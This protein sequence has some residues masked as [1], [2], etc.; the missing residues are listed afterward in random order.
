MRKPESQSP[1]NGDETGSTVAPIAPPKTTAAE[2]VAP[3]PIP[4]T[5]TDTASTVHEL[6]SNEVESATAAIENAPVQTTHLLDVSTVSDSTPTPSGMAVILD[7]LAARPGTQ[8]DVSRTE[9]SPVG[10]IPLC[11]A[12]A[13][14]QRT[15]L[16]VDDSATIRRVVADVLQPRGYRVIEAAD[17][18][19]GI[20]EIASQ[21]PDLILLDI[22]MPRLDGY[23][24][25][26]L[27]KGHA[28]TKD[29]P[30]VMLSGKDGTFDKL[31]GRLAG[32]SDYITK[33]FETNVLIDK[34]ERYL[35]QTD[36]SHKN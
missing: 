29:I 12:A 17:G 15:V 22:S 31:R 26:R 3:L 19:A 24:L 25:C 1:A 21:R 10:S 4:L 7:S 28:A 35:R 16:V 20:R 34:V 11:A 23:R 14:D 6:P 8:E 13:A 5:V 9:S 33:P 36:V 18:I 2:T 32:S 30:V 27:V